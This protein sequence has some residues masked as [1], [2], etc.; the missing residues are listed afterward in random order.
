MEFITKKGQ[1]QDE[2]SGQL[3][4]QLEFLTATFFCFK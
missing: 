3:V 1:K 4:E 2:S